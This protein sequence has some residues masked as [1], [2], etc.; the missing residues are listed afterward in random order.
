MLPPSNT[1]L[2]ASNRTAPQF[3]IPVSGL[4]E[5]PITHPFNDYYV[6][7][8]SHAQ[9]FIVSIACLG[10]LSRGLGS[11]EE[12][13]ADQDYPP[14]H[15]YHWLLWEIGAP[16]RGTNGEFDSSKLLTGS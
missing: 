11:P 16:L 15:I 7:N 1:T 4:A 2:A 9:D 8:E 5:R 3:S 6:R 10:Q 12:I 13:R 14:F